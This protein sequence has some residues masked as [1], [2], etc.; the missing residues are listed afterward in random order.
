MMSTI[1]K[2]LQLVTL[3]FICANTLANNA[4]AH[5]SNN[6]TNN[7]SNAHNTNK[8]EV[9]LVVLGIAQDG[10]YPQLNCY[11][12]HCQAGWDDPSKRR[13]ATS[14][15]LIDHRKKTKFLFEATPDIKLQLYRLHQLAPD[16]AYRLSGVMLTHGHM[17]HYTGLMHFG[18]E[19]A[20]SKDLPVFAMPRMQQYLST[21]GPWSQLV[22]LNNIKLKKLQ[23]K[24]PVT[25]GKQLTIQPLLVPHRDEFTETVGYRIYGP[26]KTALFIPD[27]DKWQK[28]S[29]NISD[30][31]KQ[32]D[33]ALLDAT[34]FGNGELP[35]RDMSEVPHPF[36]EE[37]MQLF[38]GLSAKDKNKVIFIH[39][40]HSNPL[41]QADSAAQ[42]KV[43]KAGFRIAE[44]GLRLGL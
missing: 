29:T 31:V 13:L 5:D 6:N 10:G 37:S 14:L 28:W 4:L 22:K 19:A 30:V 9:E 27:I 43:I 44:E 41:L 42:K 21:N 12:P 1:S 36:V 38:A 8:N 25:L 34:F 17:G 15:G 20:G 18:R 3:S 23:D 32:V 39:F 2:W 40:N 24:M 35:N 33:Y 11:K 7:T 26:N 16:D